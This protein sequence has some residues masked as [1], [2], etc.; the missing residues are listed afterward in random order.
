MAC[1]ASIILDFFKV[2]H[3]MTITCFAKFV[4]TY[5]T[6]ITSAL[7]TCNALQYITTKFSITSSLIT[8]E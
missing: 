6:S 4:A 5:I 7:K 8:M 2:M 1:N 3:Y